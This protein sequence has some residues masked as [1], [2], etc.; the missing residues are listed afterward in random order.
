LTVAA[1]GSS[2]RR[3]DVNQKLRRLC[4]AAMT[5]KPMANG[6]EVTRNINTIKRAPLHCWLGFA[7]VS[8]GVLASV[9]A[10]T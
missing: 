7:L 5:E 8:A 10:K 2:G 4:G 6:D 1:G 9:C 3:H